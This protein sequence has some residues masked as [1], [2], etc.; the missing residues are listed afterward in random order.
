MKTNKTPQEEGYYWIEYSNGE[1]QI[2][3]LC[4]QNYDE[5]E[6]KEWFLYFIGSEDTYIAGDEDIVKWYKIKKPK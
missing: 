2:A 5:Y 3:E 4:Y 1:K 6:E